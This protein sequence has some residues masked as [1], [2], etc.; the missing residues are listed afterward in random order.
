MCILSCSR[1]V[2]G[3]IQEYVNYRKLYEGDV[4][5][6]KDINWNSEGS[7]LFS[8]SFQHEMISLNWCFIISVF[9]NYLLSSIFSYIDKQHIGWKVNSTRVWAQALGAVNSLRWVLFGQ[10][11][12]RLLSPRTSS[13]RG[14]PTDVSKHREE[15]AVFY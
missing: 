10:G 14:R 13:M 8:L 3:P 15:L 4:E 12:L 11:S 5:K 1:Q 9:S 6:Q 7:Q 2:L